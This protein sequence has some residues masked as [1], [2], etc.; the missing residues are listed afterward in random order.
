MAKTKKLTKGQSR[1]IK[2]NQS[3]KL[4]KAKQNIHWPD[5]ELG[6]VQ[7]GVIISRFGQHADVEA[8]DSQIYR[9]NI[10][11]TVGSIVCGDSVIW[12]QG[13]SHQQ[14]VSGVIEAVEPRTSELVRPDVYDGIKPIAANIDQLFIVSSFLPAFNADIIDRYLVAAEQTNITPIILLNKSDLLDDETLAEIDKQL[15]IYRDIGYKVLQASSVT[16][17]GLSQL[18]AELIDKTSIFVGQSGVGKSTLVNTLLPE[19]ELETKVVSENSGLGQHTTTVARLYHFPGGGRLID[20]PGIR[21]FGVW[22]MEPEHVFKGFIEFQPYSGLCKFRDCKHKS[23]P[24]CAL[25]AAVEQGEISKNR[26]NS[27]QRIVQSINDNKLTS[28]FNN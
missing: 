4:T 14:G 18:T 25:Q 13:K 11:R 3:K 20:S 1:R 26:F 22:H 23:D 9:C 10:R 12:R 17:Q 27:Y 15:S 21:E 5:D 2:S 28:R 19:L 6:D 16:Q 7:K 8:N 24:G